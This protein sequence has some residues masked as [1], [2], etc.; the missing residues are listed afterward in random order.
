MNSRI[1]F[2]LSLLTVLLMLGGCQS[3]YYGTMEKLGWHK[4]DI[5]VDRVHDAR[6]EQEQAKVEFADALEQFLAVTQVDGG[7]LEQRYRELSN[8]Y[9]SSADQAQAVR[10]RIDAVENVAEALFKEWQEE[11]KEYSSN[12]LRR[13]SETQL[14][15]TRLRYEEL[16]GA[17]HEAESRMDPV[18]A[19]LHDQV[20]FLKHNL[21]ARAI[22]S[23]QETATT[24][25]QDVARLIEQMQESIDRANKFIDEMNTQG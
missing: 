6:D 24:L 17:M 4:R 14:R 3:A 7:E 11:L 23:L 15:Q 10:D 12:E 5:L 13:S 19:A 21:N 8:A 20:L 18:L 2:G 1:P 9:E 25:Q 16:I 22:A